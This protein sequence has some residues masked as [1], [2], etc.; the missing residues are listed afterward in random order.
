[1]R[2]GRGLYAAG[3]VLLSALV[4]H[5]DSISPSD[6]TIIVGRPSLSKPITTLQFGVLIDP[7][8]GGISDFDNATGQN[9][10]GLILTVN[11]PNAAEAKAAG[12]SC[13]NGDVLSNIFS[14]CT[15][16]RQGKIL[17]ITLTGG[18]ITSCSGGSC[19]ADSEFFVDLN[20]GDKLGHQGNPHG[21]GGWD[22]DSIEVRAIT[23][24]EPSTWALFL[25]GL[26]GFWLR[27]KPK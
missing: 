2:P 3:L 12:V 26:A 9:W 7:S 8:G 10:I 17:T 14:S 1:M 19:P 5:A 25:T 23:T 13:S 16:E 11:F 24:P 6:P 20:T 18:E 4:A 22:D 15:S 27:Q 21:K